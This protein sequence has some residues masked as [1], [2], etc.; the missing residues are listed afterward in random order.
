[1]VF[2]G[3]IRKIARRAASSKRGEFINY[4]RDGWNNYSFIFYIGGVSA[5]LGSIFGIAGW[6]SI[7]VTV[8]FFYYAGRFVKAFKEEKEKAE[9][10]NRR[11]IRVKR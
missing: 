11:N 2:M 8:A 1:M 7:V 5:I 3:I 9:R 4:V 10:R 6:L